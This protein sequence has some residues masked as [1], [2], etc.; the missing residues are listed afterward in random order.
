MTL[1]TPFEQSDR[2]KVTQTHGT[3][4]RSD[5]NAQ[6]T[7]SDV[8]VGSEC[9]AR[10]SEGCPPLPPVG[11]PQEF[12]S[13]FEDI[14]DESMADDERSQAERI[15]NAICHFCAYVAVAG[16]LTL[17]VVHVISPES[18]PGECGPGL[19]DLSQ[20]EAGADQ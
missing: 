13:P 4:L 20:I 16:I 1:P 3:H 2:P 12:R 5:K 19:H 9:R 14:N 11:S 7:T 15:L 17:L 18:C 8:L 6:P 10:V